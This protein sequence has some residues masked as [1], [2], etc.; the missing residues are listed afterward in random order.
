MIAY[1]SRPGLLLGLDG[2][3][4]ERSSLGDLITLRPR[5]PAVRHCDLVLFVARDHGRVFMGGG[6][7]G[8]DSIAREVDEVAIEAL[9]ERFDLEELR[10]ALARRKVL[11]PKLAPRR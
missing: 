8:Y 9:A 4:V 3:R 10:R 2:R 6:Q 1:A 5:T 11:P 7:W